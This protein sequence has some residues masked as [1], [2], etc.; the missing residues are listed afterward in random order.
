MTTLSLRQTVT[1][2]GIFVVVSTSLLMLD[3]RDA[4]DPL[5]EGLASVITP[6]S[7]TFASIAN[8]PG[9]QSE[10]EQE[11]EQTQAELNAALAENANL[12]AQIA[13]FEILDEEKRVEAERPELDYM[14]AN[15]LL[16]DATGTQYFIIIDLGADDDIEIG[17]AVTDPDFYVGQVVEVDDTTAK[18]MFIGDT[19]ASVGAQ[20]LDS[21]ADGIVSGRWQQGG[22]LIMENVDRASDPEVGEYIVTSQSAVTETRGVPP[23]LIIGTVIQVPDVA[24]GTS[25]LTLEVRPAVEY[26]ELRTVWVVMPHE[27]E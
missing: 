22:R 10:L 26:D 23:N 18:V 21:R 27:E 24:G 19:S 8:G 25:D 4:L 7:R 16:R 13:E 1:L 9:Y 3:R 5:R 15:V 2:I 20:L 12:V 6:I 11:L 17:M 14:A